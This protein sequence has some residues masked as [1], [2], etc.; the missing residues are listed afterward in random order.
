[1]GYRRSGLDE[2][3]N[4]HEGHDSAEKDNASMGKAMAAEAP[5]AHRFVGTPAA[6]KSP[7][8]IPRPHF[9]SQDLPA[10]GLRA[11]SL[12]A[13]AFVVVG[14]AVLGYYAALS[15]SPSSFQNPG[16]AAASVPAPTAG[17]DPGALAVPPGP[18][19]PSTASITNSTTGLPALPTGGP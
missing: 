6:G 1:M 12:V 18:P 10:K 14:V 4:L 5:E 16:G 7:L 11:A 17:I 9:H 8:G 19:A 13:T 2:E 3:F 15:G